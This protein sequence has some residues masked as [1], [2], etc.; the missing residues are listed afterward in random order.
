MNTT[1][2]YAN[3]LAMQ[4]GKRMN[5]ERLRRIIEAKTVAEAMKM[6]GDFGY[7]YK[8]GCSI[9]E[10]VVGET[11]RLIEFIAENA[12]NKKLKNALT[13]R[14]VY[15]NAKLAYKSRFIEVPSDG[16]YDVDFDSKQI[17]SGDYEEADKFM[18]AAIELLDE[19]NISSPQRIDLELTR[20]MYEYV[21]SCGIPAVKKYFRAEIDMKNILSAAR[22][23]RLKLIGDEFIGGGT[24]SVELLEQAASADDGFKEYFENTPYAE[25]AENVERNE[26]KDLWKAENE[27]DDHLFFMTAKDVAQ[28]GSY[29]PFLNY[30][31]ETLIELKTV[32]TALV[33]IKTSSRDGFYKRIPAIYG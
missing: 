11:N 27:T 5:M 4:Y 14:F 26:F 12:A 3:I 17:A 29:E 18:T 25:F 32:K 23:K 2:V 24:V 9:D 13:A 15:N 28:V 19:Q 30:Y 8:D 31:A 16:Y 21:L 20:A 7:A 1:K 33:C 6:L 22:M 10:F